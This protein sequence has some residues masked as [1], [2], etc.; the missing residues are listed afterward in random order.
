MSS[1]GAQVKPRILIQLTASPYGGVE[2]HAYYL[3]LL[4]AKNQAE[5]TLTSQRKFELNQEWTDA[6]KQAG[7]RIVAPPSWTKRIHGPWGLVPAR[8]HLAWHLPERFF[9]VAIGQGHGG[10]FT[11]LRRFVKPSGL[12]L[13]HEYWYGVPTRGDNYPADFRTPSCQVFPYRIRR[14]VS[15]MDGI[16]TGCARARRNLVEIQRVRI[17]LHVIPPLNKL[18][19][20]PEAIDKKYDETS[21]LRLALFGRL[22]HGKG[23]GTILGIW[24]ELNIGP[25]ELHFY[26]V[27]PGDR[28]RRLAEQMSLSGVFFHGAYERADLPRLLHET[29]VGLMLSFEE[30]Y[31][32]VAW[33][34]MTCGV[35]FVMT[36]VGASPEFTSGNPDGLQAPVEPKGIKKGIEEM[37]RRVRSGETSRSRL[38][39]FH[40]KH[41]SYDRAAQLHLQSLLEPDSFWPRA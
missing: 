21:T 7:V 20:V 37:V 28:F 40:Q 33:E 6:L 38:Q 26:G 1:V 35:P 11:W 10:S 41:F 3:S 24:R 4:L 19:G 5:V 22:G 25:A 2:T 16:V 29:D 30:G 23:V 9:D 17:P 32:L 18:Q 27:D 31:G 36:D 15:R 14:M 12:C 39:A 13:W 34:Y 8:W